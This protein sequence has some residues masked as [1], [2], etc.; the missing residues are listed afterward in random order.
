MQ[1]K[2]TT[3]I[4]GQTPN[5][6]THT[7]SRNSAFHEGYKHVYNTNS[8]EECSANHAVTDLLFKFLTLDKD[9]E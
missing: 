7:G 5:T 8:R 3:S 6:H 2:P 4:M 9:L 1:Y